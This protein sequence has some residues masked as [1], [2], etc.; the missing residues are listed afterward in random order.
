M[1]FGWVLLVLVVAVAAQGSWK[2]G[3]GTRVLTPLV[4]KWWGMHGMKLTFVCR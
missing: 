3:V 1:R 4:R 2:V